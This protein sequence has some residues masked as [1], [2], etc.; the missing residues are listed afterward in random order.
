[1]KEAKITEKRRKLQQLTQIMNST[2]TIKKKL[3]FECK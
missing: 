2:F 1:M 3:Q